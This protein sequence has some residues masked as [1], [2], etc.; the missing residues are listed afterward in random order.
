MFWVYFVKKTLFVF[1]NIH[2]QK[3]NEKKKKKNKKPKK[4]TQKKTQKKSCYSL[5]ETP[6]NI[7]SA[8][9]LSEE[10]LGKPGT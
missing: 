8:Y 9:S 7:N 3:S 2:I 5:S 10:F 4:K 1:N 6:A